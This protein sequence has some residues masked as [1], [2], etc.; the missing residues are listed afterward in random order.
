MSPSAAA[1]RAALERWALRPRAWES[2]PQ[3]NINESHLVKAE[4]GERYVLQRI[5]KFFDPR[6]CRDIQRVTAHL[7]QKGLRSPRIVPTADGEASATVNRETWRLSTWVPGRVF[8]RVEAPWQALEAGRALAT[9]HGAMDDFDAPFEAR[10][11]GVH[12]SP[13]HMAAL[14]EA[15]ETCRDAPRRSETLPV[16]GAILEFW[17]E[18]PALAETPDRIVHGDPK[19]ANL[20]F[21]AEEDTWLAWIDL[22]TVG[23]MA[24]PLELGDAFRSWCQPAGE[25]AEGNF[26]LEIFEAGCRG[27]AEAC[28]SRLAE[29]A[30]AQLVRATERIG[31]ELAA[32]FCRDAL[33]LRYF[34]W[35]P[36]RFPDAGAHH[37]ARARSQLA[38]ARA[39]RADRDEAEARCAA[40][41]RPIDERP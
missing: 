10:R 34:G 14:E 9:F 23:R 19:L 15:M 37:L 18:T 36:T 41:F 12:D 11:L 20:V 7:T 25:D 13:A 1:A 5:S 40:V 8:A 29:E 17:A 24:L 27:Y 21:A 28:L 33:E 16:A 6:V 31:I 3:G 2:L 35:D 38:F 26:E 30:G 32:R 4:D 39:V 22:D